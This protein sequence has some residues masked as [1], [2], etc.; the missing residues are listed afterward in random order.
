MKNETLPPRSSLYLRR[1]RSPDRDPLRLAGRHGSAGPSAG[2][3]RRT[4]ASRRPS[5]SVT[6]LMTAPFTEDEGPGDR[7]RREN[8]WLAAVGLENW[9]MSNLAVV[10]ATGKRKFPLLRERLRVRSP[11]D[12]F[13]EVEPYEQCRSRRPARTSQAVLPDATYSCSRTPTI[14]LVKRLAVSWRTSSEK[15]RVAADRRQQPEFNRG[16]LRTSP[17]WCGFY[18]FKNPLIKRAVA[19]RILL[20]VLGAGR[21]RCGPLHPDRSTP[22]L[23]KVLQGPRR[24]GTVFGRRR[25]PGCG[26]RP[27][28][29]LRKTSS[30]SSSSSKPEHRPRQDPFTI[31]VRTKIA[32]VSFKNPDDAQDPLVYIFRV[33]EHGRPVKPLKPVP[34]PSSRKRP[35]ILNWRYNPPRPTP[36]T[37]A[38]IPVRG[39]PITMSASKP[40]STTLQFG[41]SKTLRGL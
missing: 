12:G 13:F 30:S 35:T 2:A 39:Y 15:S 36:H 8:N 31:P 19:S 4:R 24:T 41:V 17:G 5:F 33:W 40:A 22:S 14:L 32:A 3:H 23:Q 1:P 28:P 10:A 34:E 26:W 29:A 9:Q 7:R 20:Y 16:G 37:F 25:K 6:R 21:S 38:G 11:A 18:C 27:P